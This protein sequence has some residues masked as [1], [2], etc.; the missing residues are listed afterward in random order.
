MNDSGW[1]FGLVE[2]DILIFNTIVSARS[3]PYH[4]FAARSEKSLDTLRT[5]RS[6]ASK[7]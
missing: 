7:E 4:F 2:D 1:W 3:D 5:I 6:F